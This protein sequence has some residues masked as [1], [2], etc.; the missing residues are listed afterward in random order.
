MILEKN[1]VTSKHEDNKIESKIVKL[2]TDSFWFIKSLM[3]KNQPPPPILLGALTTSLKMRCATLTY[4]TLHSAHI[5]D[6]NSA[7]LKDTQPCL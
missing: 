3:Q 1:N 2:L 7:S 5:V 6:V 4:T